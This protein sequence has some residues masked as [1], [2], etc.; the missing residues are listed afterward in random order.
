MQQLLALLSLGDIFISSNIQTHIYNSFC[1]AIPFSDHN[2]LAVL[3]MYILFTIIIS[4]LFF[5]S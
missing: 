1:P 5:P 2:F 4:L 3:T